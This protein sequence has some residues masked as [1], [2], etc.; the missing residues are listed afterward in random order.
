[1]TLTGNRIEWNQKGGFCLKNAK[2]WRITGNYFDRNG[3]PAVFLAA[4]TDI[5]PD[6]D[7][8]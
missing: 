1:M 4:G 2:L 7:P 5:T 8:R 3:G 6:M